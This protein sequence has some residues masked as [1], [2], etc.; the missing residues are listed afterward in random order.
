MISAEEASDYDGPTI[1]SASI[2]QQAQPAQQ[3]APPE[4]TV[5]IDGGNAFYKA[6][7]AAGWTP[8]EATAWLKDILGIEA[9]KNS[10]DIP[11]SKFQ[12]AMEWANTKAP[13]RVKVE[14]AFD[15]LDW[16][17]EERQKLVA[18]MK[19][20]WVKID[21]HLSREIDKKNQAQ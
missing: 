9:P 3:A 2:Q 20:D 8:A 6:Y 17:L 15:V 19:V 4:E 5:G 11:K 1:D 16:T 21:E 7:K 18:E 12:Q 10:K 13:I 14:G